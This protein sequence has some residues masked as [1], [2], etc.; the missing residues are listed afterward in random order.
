MTVE[1][2]QKLFGNVVEM[3]DVVQKTKYSSLRS[4]HRK[5]IPKTSTKKRL[6]VLFV[7]I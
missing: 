4:Y 5:E 2:R 7:Q 3:T 6:L 1:E